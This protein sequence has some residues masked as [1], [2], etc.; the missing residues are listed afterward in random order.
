MYFSNI[1]VG[2]CAI[3]NPQIKRGRKLLASSVYNHFFAKTPDKTK[4]GKIV[5]FIT[6]KPRTKPR[7]FDGSRLIMPGLAEFKGETEL[8]VEL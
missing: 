2:N 4:E 1:P 5:A 7:K 8:F 6:S 3:Y